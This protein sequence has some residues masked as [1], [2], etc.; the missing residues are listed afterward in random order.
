M[1]GCDGT[2]C[3]GLEWTVAVAVGAGGVVEGGEGG[4]ASLGVVPLGKLWGDRSIAWP[5]G[6]E[7]G[8]WLE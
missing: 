7:L 8:D 5:T 6:R 3:G 2:D 4:G 1:T